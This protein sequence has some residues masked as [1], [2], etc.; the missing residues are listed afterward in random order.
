[1]AGERD[2]HR[3]RNPPWV[4]IEGGVLPRGVG[5]FVVLREA[6]LLALVEVARAGEREHE[7]RCRAGATKAETASG[8]AARARADSV[9]LEVGGG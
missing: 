8:L 9:T 4:P 1:M 5:Q 6:E 3:V 7:G 2:I